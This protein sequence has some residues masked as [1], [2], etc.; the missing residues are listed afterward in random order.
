MCRNICVLT[1]TCMFIIA[2]VSVITEAAKLGCCITH[3]LSVS[4]KS[5]AWKAYSASSTC[6]ASMCPHYVPLSNVIM[7]N[8][9]GLYAH[10]AFETSGPYMRLHYLAYHMLV[11]HKCLYAFKHIHFE[12]LP[13]MHRIHHTQVNRIAKPLITAFC[14]LVY[15]QRLLCSLIIAPR[16]RSLT[17]AHQQTHMHKINTHN[18]YSYHVAWL[19]V[20]TQFRG[21]H[22]HFL[23]QFPV[24]F[25]RCLEL[26]GKIRVFQHSFLVLCVNV[27]ERECASCS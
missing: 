14:I 19:L 6:G 24:L 10:S 16:I 12:P 17:H 18:T 27:C 13:F 4:R 23:H 15:D 8:C 7:H 2:N 5:S 20:W 9:H 3:E 1:Y 21:P 11:W 26:P 22:L 25:L